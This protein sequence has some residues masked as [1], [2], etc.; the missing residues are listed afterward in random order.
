MNLDQGDQQG[1]QLPDLFGVARRRGKLIAIVS[2]AVILV[3][4]WIAMALPNIYTSYALILVEPQ[5]VDKNLVNSGVQGG[6]LAERLGLMTAEILGRARLSRIINELELYED[7]HDDMER[8]EVVELMRSFFSVE[9]VV[10]EL[11]ERRNRNKEQPFTTFK[12]S[13][14][15]DSP[16]MARDVTQ[17]I[18]NDFINANISRRTEVTAKSLDFMQDEIAVLTDRLSRIESQIG[19][20]KEANVGSL[21]EEFAAHQQ[22]LQHSIGGLRDAQRT[23][24]TANSDAEFWENQAMTA[25]GL[26]AEVNPT[27][28][29]YRKR[30]LEIEFDSM[31][32]RGFTSRHPD[33]IRVQAELA[34]LTEQLDGSTEDG[35]QPRSTGERSALAQQNRAELRASAAKIEVERLEETVVE[36]EQNLAKTPAVA[37]QLD[38]LQRE[39]DQHYASYMDFSVRLQQAA[40]QADLERRQLGE[41]FRIL[42]PAERPREPSSPN[43]ILL[44]ILGT[45]LGISLGGGIGLIA[46]VSD[47]SIH[48]STALQAALGIPVLISVPKIMLEPDRIARSRR[49]LRESLAAV[50]VVVFVL[51]GGVATYLLVNGS[52]WSKPS[53]EAVE[54]NEGSSTEARFDLGTR[55]G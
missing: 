35:E 10:T 12:I 21:P 9:P 25:S 29:A 33:L 8:F 44:L 3:T 20:V 13:F 2:G 54:E 53:E 45:I 47:S 5:S 48:T 49:I 18:A 42:E 40:V 14:Q 22:R 16:T 36:L 15:S 30:S 6:E 11:E 50:G 39:Y 24:D 41:H 17:R 55:R 23:L 51:I 46:E 43:R 28:P 27:S 31:L 32:A 34:I 38:A 26:S 19:D 37:E 7:E 52:G 1:I 4:F